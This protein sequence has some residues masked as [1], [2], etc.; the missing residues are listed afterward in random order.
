MA[1]AMSARAAAPRG[2]PRAAAPTTKPR[3]SRR[4]SPTVVPHGV[5]HIW[6]EGI[7]FLGTGITNAPHRHFTAS[8]IFGV[9]GPFAFRSGRGPW[10][11]AEAIVTGPN[12]LQSM[13]T[14]GSQVVIMQ[15]DPETDAYV[16]L[17]QLFAEHGNVI[18]PDPAIAARLAAT[19]RAMTKDDA[20]DAARVWNLALESLG[21]EWQRPHVLDPR[22]TQVLD[23]IKRA[24]PKAPPVPKLAAAVGVSPS[25]LLHLWK[26]AV[27][28][29]LRRYVL[30]LRLRHVVACVAIGRSLTEA[31]HE[32]GF[33]DSAHLSRTFRSMFGLRLSSLFGATAKVG[34]SFKFPDQELS[35]PHGPYD[36]ERW[37]AA[38]RALRRGA[39]GPTR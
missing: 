31:A 20:F 38:A 4:P 13:D 5:V 24:F 26:D 7:L 36:R 39:T 27:G 1:A 18:E 3:S 30:W 11:T 21:G 10:R 12:L 15:V 6:H 28:I 32:A 9:D 29:A 16:R 14:R 8:L 17:A 35:G 34:L 25:R 23:I 19:V 2:R 37:D 22:V 33:A